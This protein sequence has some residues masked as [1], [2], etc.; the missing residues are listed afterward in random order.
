[1]LYR[2]N[3]A[4]RDTVELA[5]KEM[6]ITDARASQPTL[7]C[8]G[9]QIISTVMKSRA[10]GHLEPELDS[11]R[12]LIQDLT[13]A[14]HVALTA[15][16]VHRFAERADL[17]GKLDNSRPARFAHVDVSAATAH[18]FSKRSAPQGLARFRRSAH[19]NLWCPTSPPPQDVPLALCEAG[20]FSADDLIPADAV[21]DRDGIDMWA[22]EGL[23]FA[24]APQHRWVWFSAM[25]IGE[26]LLFK[27]FDS[28]P[29]RAC[30]VPHVAFDNPLAP[31]DAAPR[32]S[33]ELRA[34]A[35][36]A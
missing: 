22:M 2:A 27:T 13:G 33:C 17:S 35:Y 7:D 24:H 34:I 18:A 12:A 14:D 1:M 10:S 3:D 26:A 36:W 8:N 23:V 9:Y 6:Q 15:P 32:S 31:P 19:Y 20:S 4:S 30:C 11:V 28:D 25:E 5:P 21:F 29:T 16:P